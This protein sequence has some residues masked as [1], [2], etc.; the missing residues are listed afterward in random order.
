MREY[1]RN[2]RAIAALLQIEQLDQVSL[3]TLQQQLP[4]IRKLLVATAAAPAAIVPAPPAAAGPK[5]T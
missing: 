1:E 5:G 3:E 2:A 4:A